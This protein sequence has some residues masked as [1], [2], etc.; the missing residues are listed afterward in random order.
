M[1]KTAKSLKTYTEMEIKSI[2]TCTECYSNANKYPTEWCT[3]VCS[4]LHL[5]VW[6]K[7]VGYNYWPGKCMSIHSTGQ[8][9]NIRFFGDHT[10]ADIAATNC[11]LYSTKNPSSKPVKSSDTYKSALKVIYLVFTKRFFKKNF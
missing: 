7:V 4:K 8:L 10:E 3:M 9:V 2:K 5:V 11:F 6:G 1:V